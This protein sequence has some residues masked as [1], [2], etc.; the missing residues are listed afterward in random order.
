MLRMLIENNKK[1]V[2]AMT[3]FR[4]AQSYYGNTEEMIQRQ[5]NN[6]IP[7]GNIYQK[8]EIS[9]ARYNCFWEYS[10]LEDKRW[11]Y[12]LCINK[13][14]P[15]DVSEKELKSEKWLD[16][17]WGE[18]ELKDKKFIYWAVMDP[19]SKEEKTPIFLHIE[20]CSKK[21]LAVSEKD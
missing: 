8:R 13:R 4:N 15:K 21:K 20:E 3:K 5:R 6:L 17:W 19:L 2:E 11:V 7:G 14:D 12:E 16:N 1:G 18:L 10:D 9:E